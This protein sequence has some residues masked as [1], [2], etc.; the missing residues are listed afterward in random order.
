MYTNKYSNLFN[1]WVLSSAFK[2]DCDFLCSVRSSEWPIIQAFRQSQIFFNLWLRLQLLNFIAENF[3]LSQRF[4]LNGLFPLI[5]HKKNKM[6]FVLS[7]K[8]SY[9]LS[10][11]IVGLEI[12]VIWYFCQKNGRFLVGLLHHWPAS[13]Y[14]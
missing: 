10:L 3:R 1:I 9:K 4:R 11:V 14:M 2:Y 13:R 5:D 7:L 8:S 12:S 6:A